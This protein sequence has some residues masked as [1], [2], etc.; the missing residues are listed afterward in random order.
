MIRHLRCFRQSLLINFFKDAALSW[1][2]IYHK[3][4]EVEL[5]WGGLEIR[6]SYWFQVLSLSCTEMTG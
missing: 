6:G 3:I 1:V 4:R 5:I 2:F